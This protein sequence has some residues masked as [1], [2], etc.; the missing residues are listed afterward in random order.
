MRS[1]GLLR[2]VTEVGLLSCPW[3]DWDD[4]VGGHNVC[5][6]RYILE[7][8][9]RHT[10]MR[11]GH[12]SNWYGGEVREG[13]KTLEDVVRFVVKAGGGKEARSIGWGYASV[14]LRLR[15]YGSGKG[16]V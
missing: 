7:T 12:V 16:L 6:F 9:E 10:K 2:G 15:E 3:M 5:V 11:W 13:Y 14:G 1:R 8:G 4:K